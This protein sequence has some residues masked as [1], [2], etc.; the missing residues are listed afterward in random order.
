M[1]TCFPQ[2]KKWSREQG[3]TEHGIRNTQYVLRFTFYVP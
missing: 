1:P 2:G 3:D